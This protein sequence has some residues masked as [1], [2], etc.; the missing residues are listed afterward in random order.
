MH[1]VYVGVPFFQVVGVH[2]EL[3]DTFVSNMEAQSAAHRASDP[4]HAFKC[5]QRTSLLSA[6]DI[7]SDPDLLGEFCMQPRQAGMR[8]AFWEEIHRRQGS[9]LGPGSDAEV[10]MNRSLGR[11][12]SKSQIEEQE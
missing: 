1:H 7:A 4:V 12:A 8:Q 10:S 6:A 11:R 5:I 9:G 2:E 3:V